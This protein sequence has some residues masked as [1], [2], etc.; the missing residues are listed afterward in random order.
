MEHDGHNARR[1]ADDC[2]CERRESDRLPRRP[3]GTAEEVQFRAGARSAPSDRLVRAAESQQQRHRI[4]QRS[5]DQ[6]AWEVD[7]AAGI[8]PLLRPP[9]PMWKLYARPE[10][11]KVN[12][13]GFDR[14]RSISRMT[15]AFWSVWKRN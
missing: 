1:P 11:R 6:A 9:S 8:L 12:N 14:N 15:R 5:R 2:V 7:S 3:A 13:Y 10:F 4:F